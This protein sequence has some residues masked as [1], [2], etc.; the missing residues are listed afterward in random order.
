VSA[1]SAVIVERLRRAGIVGAGGAGFPTHV[2]AGSQAEFVIANGAECEP[3]LHKDKEILKHFAPKVVEGLE[4]LMRSTGAREGVLAMKGKYADVVEACRAALAGKPH[5]RLQTLGDFYPVGDEFCLV[6]DVTGRLIPPGGLPIQVGVVVNNVETLLNAADAERT[7]VV[8]TFLSVA[9]AV[10]EP[11]T[12]R[13]PVGVSMRE[14]IELAGGSPEA[15]PVVLDGGAMMG[16]VAKDLSDPVKKTSG[17]LI[18]LPKDHPL[19]WR[20]SQPREV[21]TRIGKSACDQCSFCTE[22]CPRYLLG[23]DIRPHMVMRSLGM[24]DPQR[25]VLSEWALLCCE[26]SICSLYACPEN[27]DPRN[28]CVA[29]KGDLKQVGIDW[30]SSAINKGQVAKAHEMRNYRMVPIARLEKRMDL[31]KYHAD[32]P[33]KESG[34]KPSRV[35]IPLKQHVGVPCAASVKPGD[36]VTRGQLLGDVPAGALGVPVH[37]SIDGVVK[38]VDDAVTIER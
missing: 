14:V 2:K 5:L 21:F 26:C 3:L 37:S 1:E 12:V 9:G 24:S 16:R 25:K 10:R 13:V 8:D 17:G 38:A 22:L 32:A 15:D 33:L 29:A 34:W 4:L 18:V 27:L 6:F 7:P 23:Y 20:K 11:C 30:K 31:D 28:A 36:R 19:I 35:R